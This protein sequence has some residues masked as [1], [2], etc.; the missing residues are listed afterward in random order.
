MRICTCFAPVLRAV[1][2]PL[3]LESTNSTTHSTKF[4]SRPGTPDCDDLAALR[5]KN[6]KSA[7]SRMEKLMV[8]MLIAMKPMSFASCAVCASVQVLS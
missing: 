4:C 6:R 3:T 8:S 7:P 2:E 1:K 5:K